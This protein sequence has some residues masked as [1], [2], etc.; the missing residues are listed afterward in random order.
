MIMDYLGDIVEL[1]KYEIDHDEIILMWAKMDKEQ[2]LKVTF[3]PLNLTE[4]YF[5]IN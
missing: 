1:L 2:N 5:E 4:D 3:T